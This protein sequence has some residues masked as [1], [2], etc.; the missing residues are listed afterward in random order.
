MRLTVFN[1]LKC[2]NIL[3][4]LKKCREL[5]AHGH[6]LS[7]DVEKIK[8]LGTA[9]YNSKRE[10]GISSTRSDGSQCSPDNDINAAGAECFAA[11]AYG[12][13][14]NENISRK[15]DGGADFSVVIN[16]ESKTVE[17]IWLGTYNGK[18]RDTGHLIVNPHE[19]QRWADL[20]IV[21][22]GS[23]S[24]GFIEVG[25]ATHEQLVNA[26]RKD[27]GFGPR[28]A[29]HINNLNKPQDLKALIG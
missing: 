1:I 3:G 19:P 18:P 11:E 17:V 20:Y 24:A 21:I 28:Y 25:W 16:G 5:V 27:F 23:L 10:A 4:R 8:L 15:G 7:M 6:R 26:P 13:P 29:I 2:E 9:R 12:Q 22:A 14:F